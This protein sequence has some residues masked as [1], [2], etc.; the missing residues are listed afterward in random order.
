MPML[1]QQPP[2]QFGGAYAGL[3]SRRQQLVGNWVARFTKTT[4]QRVEPGPFYDEILSQSTKTTF[5]AVTNALMTTRLTDRAGA[6]IGDALALVSEVDAVRGEVPGAPG[7]HQFRMYVRLTPD[8]VNTLQRCTEFRRAADN[9][10]YHK[11]YPINYRG[12]GG[13][14]SIQISIALDKR[15]ADIDVDYRSSSFPV[16]LFNGHLTSS[17]SDVRAGNNFDRHL[18]RWSG[19]RNW[20]RSFFGVGQSQDHAPDTPASTPLALPQKPRAGNAKIDTMV[21]DF[22]TAWLVEGNIAAAMGYVS[23]RSYACLAQ[24]R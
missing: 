4:T 5:D 7:D 9:S 18:N 21:N 15:R 10:I 13:A 3:D 8:A 6:P 11:G 1:G 17:N 20:W 24:D 12:Q 14:P 19:L 16:G 23:E 2:P 22:L